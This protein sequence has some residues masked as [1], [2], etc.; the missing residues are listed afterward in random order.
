MTD[1]ILDRPAGRSEGPREGGERGFDV[2]I[3]TFDPLDLRGS[4]AE[5]RLCGERREGLNASSRHALSVGDRLLCKWVPLGAANAPID[6]NTTEY[7]KDFLKVVKIDCHHHYEGDN[8]QVDRINRSDP[9]DRGGGDRG[10][11]RI[12]AEEKREAVPLLHVYVER[13]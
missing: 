7:E 1:S 13:R 8:N 5:L 3:E 12:E 2:I 10:S 9:S 11:T 6:T 4:E